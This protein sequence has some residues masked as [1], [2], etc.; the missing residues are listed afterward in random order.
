[1]KSSIAERRIPSAKGGRDRVS[2]RVFAP[3]EDGQGRWSCGYRIALPERTVRRTVYGADS[4]HSLMLAIEGLQ[5]EVLAAEA[6]NEVE[7]D[8]QGSKFK[9][10]R[11]LAA[12]LK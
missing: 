10:S 5:F 11:R 8:W 7:L 1:M 2:V 9:V 12:Y 4:L 6:E 3:V